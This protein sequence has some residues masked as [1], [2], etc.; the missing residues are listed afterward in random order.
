MTSWRCAWL[1]SLFVVASAWALDP[2]PGYPSRP[3]RV[4]VPFPAGGAADA[5][6]RLGGERLPARGGQAVVMENRVGASGGLGTGPRA[7]AQ[8]TSHPPPAPPP[9]R[10]A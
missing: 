4:I 8:H 6:P 7:P 2:A 3:I 10:P 5:L 9:P 1:V